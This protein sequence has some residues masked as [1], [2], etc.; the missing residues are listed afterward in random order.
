MAIAADALLKTARSN[1]R[2]AAD[3]KEKNTDESACI[4]AP[5][6]GANRIRFNGF[7]DERYTPRSA[8]QAIQATPGR[9]AV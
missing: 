1:T 7:T 6:A 4:P 9:P 3:I 5:Y 2:Q 8:S